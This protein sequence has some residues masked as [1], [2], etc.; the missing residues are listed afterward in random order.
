MYTDFYKL[1]SRPFQLTPDHRFFFKGRPHKKA[2]DYLTYGIAQGEGFIVITGDIGAGKTTLVDYIL[3]TFIG[4]NIIAAKVASTLLDADNMLRMVAAAFDLSQEGSDK[5]TV[6]KRMEMFLVDS[7]RS[8]KRVLLFVDEAQN[9]PQGALE[10]LR[11]LSNIQLEGH[12]LMQ[13]FLLG[14]PEFRRT[15]ASKDMEQLRQRVITTYHLSPLEGEETRMY[16]EHRLC[17]VGWN[18]DP[19][20]SDE[21]YQ[22]IHEATGGVPRKINLMCDR[23]LLSAFLEEGH[24]IDLDVVC[25]VVQGMSEEGLA[26]AS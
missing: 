19:N 14:Q 23:L 18:D 9:L 3:S 13:I 7:H 20:F 6:L 10:E 16:I 5:A 8:G 11:M 21:A 1:K 15:M 24:T 25:D 26:F 4:K 12:P 22:M 17:Q 2:L